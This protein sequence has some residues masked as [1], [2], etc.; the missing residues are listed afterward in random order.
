MSAPV[1]QDKCCEKCG[2]FDAIEMGDKFLC[3]DCITL[4]G[5]A[6]AEKEEES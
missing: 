5:C 2:R 1:V 6:C 4:A 3:E